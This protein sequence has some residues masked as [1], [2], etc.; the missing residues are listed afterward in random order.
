MRSKNKQKTR[1]IKNISEIRGEKNMGPMESSSP[2]P[3]VQIITNHTPHLLSK[4]NQ[5]TSVQPEGEED[6]KVFS[7]DAG[8]ASVRLVRCESPRLRSHRTDPVQ[9]YLLEL[10]PPYWF[11]QLADCQARLAWVPPLR[12]LYFIF[13]TPPRLSQVINQT[14]KHFWAPGEGFHAWDKW[15]SWAVLPTLYP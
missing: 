3:A 10:A 14:T 12:R 6:G 4:N 15:T 13:N 7:S 11:R 5:E 2:P 8:Q 1:L 9:I